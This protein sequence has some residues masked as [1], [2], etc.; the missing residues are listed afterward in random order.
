MQR[1]EPTRLQVLISRLQQ[2]VD[3]AVRN[4][5]SGDDTQGMRYFLSAV[6]GLELVIREDRNS[7]QPKIDLNELLPSVRR[8]YFYMRNQDIVG[9]TDLLEDTVMPMTARW[10]KEGGGA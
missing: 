3:S 10:L 6:E 8:L 1:K 2:Y 7:Q 5:R 9:I 4:F